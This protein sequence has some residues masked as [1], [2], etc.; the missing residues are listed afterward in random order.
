M[1]INEV[2]CRTSTNIKCP[3]R[4]E[5]PVFHVCGPR[6]SVEVAK[7]WISNEADHFKQIRLLNKSC[8]KHKR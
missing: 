5:E 3:R 4:G 7:E 1:K 6:N 2:R 8:T